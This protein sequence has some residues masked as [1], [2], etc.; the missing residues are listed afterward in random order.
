MFFFFC[1]SGSG[2]IFSK[3]RPEVPAGPEFRYTLNKDRSN[4]SGKFYKAYA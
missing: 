4:K 2:R 3:I 1:N